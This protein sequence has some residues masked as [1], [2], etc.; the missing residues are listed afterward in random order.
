MKILYWDIETADADSLFTGVVDAGTEKARPVEGPFVRL[1]GYAWNDGPV[2]ITTDP[3]E[4][5]EALDFADET[6]GH[7]TFGF[8]GLAMAWHHGLD[9]KS[10]CAKSFD[11]DPLARYD[12]PPRSREKGSAD[13]YD[14]DHVAQR[15]NLVGKITG[16]D[17]LAALKRRYK[18]YDRIPTD[19]PAYRAYLTQDVA[20]SRDVAGVL[21]RALNDYTRREHDL[22][23]Y[24]GQMTLNGFHVNQPLL[25]ERI[26]EGEE[27]KR[28]ALE[29]LNE[30]YGVPLG[31]TVLRGRKPNKTQHF[32]PHKSPLATRDG[33][34][35]LI[36]AFWELGVKHYPK[37]DK[38]FITHPVTGVRIKDIAAGREGMERMVAHYVVKKGL[39]D[40]QRL[41]DLVTT[42]TTVRTIYQ[43]AANN[44]APDGKI[45]PRCSMRQASGRLSVTPGM[46]VFGKHAGRHVEREIFDAEEGLDEPYVLITCDLSQVDMRAVAAH[47]Q[48]PNYI[49]LLGFNED[50]TPKDAHQEIANMLG[51]KRQDAKA[52][53]HGWNYGLGAN[54]MIKEGADPKI[55]W[56]FV[57]GMERRFRGLCSWREDVRAIGKSGEYLDNGFGRPMRCDPRFAY[58]QAPA[59][60][61]QGTARDITMEV[62]IR[63]LAKYPEYVYFLRNQVHD[64]WVFSVPASR[65]EEIK[66]HI[67]EAF[68]WEWRGVPILCDAAG[69]GANWGELSAK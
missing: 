65:A 34:D 52:R 8:D 20:A 47:S 38:T 36:K 29:E 56:A 35:A 67:V 11:T 26:K 18:G 39:T 6:W 10:W 51:I 9:W 57:N 64:E 21:R 43:T 48:D 54:R 55:V 5:M 49:D 22:L 13:Q 68:T 25:Q 24:T 63:L 7:N 28:A 40:V 15:Y 46:T 59:L 12:F 41:C 2:K 31:K 32:V 1:M 60:M 66:A 61:G 45:H 27:R 44:L 42:V 37:V 53:G 3:D 62:L 4:L 69:P 58:T 30:T 16:E 23:Y 33:K 50:G 14:L 19:D 17:G